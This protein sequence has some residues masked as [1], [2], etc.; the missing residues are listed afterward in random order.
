MPKRSKCMKPPR[1]AYE[2][3][4]R[5]VEDFAAG[6]GELMLHFLAQIAEAIRK[7]G[8]HKRRRAGSSTH[9][10]SVESED[11]DPDQD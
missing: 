8:A 2:E 1:D 5:I 4:A 10:I 9:R 11:P 3:S 6:G 7:R